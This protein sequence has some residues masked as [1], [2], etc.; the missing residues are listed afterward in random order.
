MDGI[1]YLEKLK[2]TRKTD[3]LTELTELT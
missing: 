2:Q 1:L 3:W